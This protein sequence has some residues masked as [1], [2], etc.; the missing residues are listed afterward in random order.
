[1]KTLILSTLLHY[2][3]RYPYLERRDEFYDIKKNILALNPN[4]Q[5][6]GKQVQHII[7]KC[8]SCNGT[9][10]F[11]EYW[12][13][14]FYR[15][16][17]PRKCWN[18][19]DGVY[20]QFY[21]LLVLWKFGKYEF[22]TFV[23][24]IEGP[25]FHESYFRDLPLLEAIQGKIKKPKVKAWLHREALLWLI[26]IYKRESFMKRL[27]KSCPVGKVY[28]PLLLINKIVFYNR[29]GVFKR[30][31]KIRFFKIKDLFKF[32][33]PVNIIDDELPF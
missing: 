31:W 29:R 25:L 12:D 20:D 24:R 30:R 22:H 19:F 11:S 1:M 5:Q 32:K 3:N 26:L 2:A 23:D 14:D 15:K 18:C 21:S 27:R 16:V 13:G 33:K 9:G 10:M 4:T 7:K 28:T 6:L 17:E 8:Y